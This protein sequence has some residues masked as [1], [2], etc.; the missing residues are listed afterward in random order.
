MSQ[1]VTVKGLDASRQRKSSC[2]DQDIGVIEKSPQGY[3]RRP[4][5]T[6]DTPI[7][8]CQLH[9]MQR[10]QFKDLRAFKQSPLSHAT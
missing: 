10:C 8:T 9:L 6:C 7:R 4:Q 1:T 3:D 5:T 2:W